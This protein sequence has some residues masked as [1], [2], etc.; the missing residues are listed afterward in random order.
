[1]YQR[2]ASFHPDASITNKLNSLNNP[3][4]L[5]PFIIQNLSDASGAVVN[6]D[7]FPIKITSL[8]PSMNMSELMEHFRLNI[9]NF[10]S[11]QA[12]F[13]P[14]A[15]SHINDT[16][17]WNQSGTASKGALVHISMPNDGTVI[18]SDYISN[19]NGTAFK[20]T[21]LTS[22]YD[23]NHPVSGN[24]EFGVYP[25]P[26]NPGSYTF[27]TMGV[28]RISDWKFA[29]FNQ[30]SNGGVF[31]GA[32]NLWRAMQANMI[33]DIIAHGGQADYY[34][35]HEFIARP[36]YDVVKDY[37]EGTISLAELKQQIGC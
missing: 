37:L 31:T 36:D 8:P 28:D 2:V 35:T 3:L 34:P 13:T 10:T 17:L 9:N 4:P 21:T 23:Y 15:D 16:Q 22:P 1:M 5:D 14:Y 20:F 27:Y 7:F 30:V 24:R 6:S 29:L 12:S 26:N 33:S 19:S 25:D 11:G 18:E 32:S